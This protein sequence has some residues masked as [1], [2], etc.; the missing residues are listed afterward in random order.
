M[1]DPQAAARPKVR[2]TVILSGFIGVIS[3]IQGWTWLSPVIDLRGVTIPTWYIVNVGFMLGLGA[4]ML[5][6]A[7]MIARYRKRGLQLG[8]AIYVLYL[9]NTAYGIVSGVRPDLLGAFTIV[10]AVAALY[11]IFR[12]LTRDPEREFFT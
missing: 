11:Y 6:A 7:V 4:L 2:G 9:G 1:L 3:L 8:L 12:Y 5:A 10:L